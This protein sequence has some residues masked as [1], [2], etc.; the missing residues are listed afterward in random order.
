MIVLWITIPLMALAVL[1]A[2]GVVIVASVKHHHKDRAERI[3][4]GQE[5]APDDGMERVAVRVSPGSEM[6]AARAVNDLTANT[7]A[8]VVRS[9]DDRHIVIAL[10]EAT[11]KADPAA[12]ERLAEEMRKGEAVEHTERI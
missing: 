12:P 6:Q 7:D 3:A 4:T 9:G 8:D 5:A 2:A 1:W 11:I 10:D